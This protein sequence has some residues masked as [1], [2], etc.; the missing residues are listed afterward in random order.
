MT[1]RTDDGCELWATETGTGPPVVLCHGGPGLWD[2][3]DDLDLPARLIRWDQRGS[4]RSDHR[5]PYSMARTVADLDAVRDHFDLDRMILLGHSWGAQLALRYALDHPTRVTALAYVSG[6]GLGWDW[7][8][9]FRANFTNRLG[10]DMA[11]WQELRDRE[12]TDAEERELAVLQWSAE[13]T[14][15]TT[16][17]TLA[18]RMATPWFGVN[19][20]CN[21]TIDIDDRLTWQENDLVEACQNLEVPTLIIDGTHDLRPRQAVDSLEN[22]LPNVTRVA[23]N[24]GHIP[25][26]EAGEEFTKTCTR[27]LLRE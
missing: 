12:R 15:P 26:L 23:L 13:F 5:G 27:H 18:E 10:P 3:F 21:T 25:W 4:G 16:A 22:A 14:D 24:T 20:E 9:T 11:R 2:M 8:T 7:H 19:Y 17:T 6:V 1:V